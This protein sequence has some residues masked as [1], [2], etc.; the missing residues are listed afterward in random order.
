MEK[1]FTVHEVVYITEIHCTIHLEEK[2]YSNQKGK[3]VGIKQITNNKNIYLIQLFNYNR[4][5][6]LHNELKTC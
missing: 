1:T 4:I 6:T 3:I 2:Y 5:W